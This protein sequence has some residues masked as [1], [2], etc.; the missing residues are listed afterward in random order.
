MLLLL[1]LLL[2]EE[3]DDSN[4][5][6]SPATRH[7]SEKEEEEGGDDDDVEPAIRQRMPCPLAVF[8]TRRNASS[9]ASVCLVVIIKDGKEE[10]GMAMAMCRR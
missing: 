8:C 7:M 1:L 3:E 10:S 4:G 6:A 9:S 2:E 5:D